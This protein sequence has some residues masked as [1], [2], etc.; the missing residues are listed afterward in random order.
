MDA[1][2]RRDVA[3]HIERI[4]RGHILRQKDRVMREFEGGWLTARPGGDGVEFASMSLD[5]VFWLTLDRLLTARDLDAARAALEGLNL[6]RVFIWLAP[7]AWDEAV[8]T[9]LEAAGARAIP[10][11]H[12][13]TL[14]RA[15]RAI[16]KTRPSLLTFRRIDP[17]E[18][19]QVLEAVRE[20][21]TVEEAV[22][23]AERGEIEF[24]AAFDGGRPV[25]MSQFKRDGDFAYLGGAGTHADFRGRGAQTGLIAARAGRAEELGIRWCISETNTAV[26]ISLNN[27]IRCGFRPVVDWKVYEWKL[28]PGYVLFDGCL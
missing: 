13:L 28:T 16:A 25:A 21:Y 2:E 8:A 9:L 3:A 20:W 1:P 5:R 26:P 17:G 23:P 18:A 7:C 6:P 19:R 11:M 22:G 10:I 14:A 27:L 12:Y 4:R 15:A 24:F